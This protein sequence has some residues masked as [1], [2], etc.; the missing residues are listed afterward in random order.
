MPPVLACPSCKGLFPAIDGPVHAYMSSSP[1][2]WAA[3]GEVLALEY[4]DRAL[5]EVHRLSVDTYAVQHPG[6][7]S[8]QAIQSVGLHL[9][10]LC[11]LL[12]RGLSPHDANDAMVEAARHKDQFTW[13]ERPA[14][15]G[16]ITVADVR[17]AMDPESHAATVRA[18]ANDAWQA[19]GP[20]HSLVREW[21]RCGTEARP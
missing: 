11:L 8:R 4:S 19:W 15:L 10:R 12:E 5:G 20:H 14:S 7:R 18:W 3:Y 1:G 13:L 9:V 2:C 16:R 6:D 21:A 17:A